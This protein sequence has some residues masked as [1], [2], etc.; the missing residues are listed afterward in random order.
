M[1]FIPVDIGRIHN[2]AYIVGDSA[3]KEVAVVDAGYKAEQIMAEVTAL[4]A[5]VNCV[6]ATHH[7]RDHCG[8][9]GKITKRTGAPL[10]GFECADWKCEI[11]EYLS[12]GDVIQIGGME[13]EVLHTPGHTPES[14][15]FLVDH[16]K[17]LAGD[18]LFVGRVSRSSPDT[19]K[20]MRIFYDT[21]H[22]RIMT[23]DDDIEVW[24]GHD[25]GPT[26]FST[27]GKERESNYVLSMPFEEFYLRE[28]DKKRK[29][30]IVP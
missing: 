27:I 2:R 21:I 10:F 12:D 1:I 17:L 6:L 20:Q 16:A 5:K 15:C 8:A 28:W 4:G 13:I 29:K 3:T 7:H 23:L 9:A 11:D 24:P 18:S 30:W 26:C 22:E 14:V 25:V 19:K